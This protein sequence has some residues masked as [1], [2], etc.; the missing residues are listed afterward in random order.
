MNFLLGFGLFSGVLVLGR[1]S[2]QKTHSNWAGGV[3]YLFVMFLLVKFEIF[4]YCWQGGSSWTCGDDMS[5]KGLT[6][7]R[8]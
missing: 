7:Q 1:V 4:F 2:E 3:Y 8:L 6:S 5:L